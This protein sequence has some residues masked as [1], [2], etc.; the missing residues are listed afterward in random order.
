MNNTRKALL[1]GLLSHL[2]AA[3][4]PF[5]AKTSLSGLGAY[6]GALCI[7]LVAVLFG[8][9]LVSATTRLKG[10]LR[11]LIA[12]AAS[13]DSMLAFAAMMILATASVLLFYGGL[14]QSNPGEFTFVVRLE[15]LFALVLAFMVLG[16]RTRAIHVFGALLGFSGWILV[17]NFASVRGIPLWYAIGYIFTSGSASMIAKSMLNR[18]SDS[19]FFLLRMSATM[20]VQI[21]LT[22]GLETKA[23]G[24]N[25]LTLQIYLSTALGGVV[26]AALFLNRYYAMARLPLW[27]YS[28]LS[29]TQMVF[30]PLFAWITGTPLTWQVILGGCVVTLGVS[31]ASVPAAP[32]RYEQVRA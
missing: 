26:L 10:C 24:Y 20:V 6:R 22:L 9:L 32:K 29:A 18:M 25:D 21:G 19:A 3:S 5:L 30:T 27:W 12:T 16:E 8:L 1:L 15:H 4:F 17:V 28:G 23:V 11:S 2:C 14:N 13:R 7:Y 31:L